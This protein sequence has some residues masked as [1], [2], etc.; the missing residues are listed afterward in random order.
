MATGRVVSKGLPI[1][2]KY[3]TIRVNLN[4]IKITAKHETE[5]KDNGQ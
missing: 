3:K 5:R 2:Q 1:S 4:T